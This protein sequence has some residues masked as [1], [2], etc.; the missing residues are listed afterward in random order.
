MSTK[1]FFFAIVMIATMV[2]SNLEGLFAQTNEEFITEISKEKI[3]L[4]KKQSEMIGRLKKNP[5]Y[6]DIKIV[7]LAS[8]PNCQK[9]GIL[10]FTIPGNNEIVE[11]KAT[12]VKALSYGDYEWNGN[13]NDDIGTMSVICTKGKVIA[14]ISTFDNAYEIYSTDNNLYLLIARDVKLEK[15]EKGRCGNQGDKTAILESGIANLA[16][17]PNTV[18]P[19]QD[20]VRILILYTTA[21]SGSVA[22]IQQTAELCISQFNS[23]LY[24]SKVSSNAY[25]ELAGV[26]FFNETAIENASTIQEAVVRLADNATAQQV[27]NSTNADV[28]VL[29]TGSQIWGSNNVGAAR[30]VGPNNNLSY[31][32]VKAQSSIG[33]HYPFVHEVG[34]LYGCYHDIAPDIAGYARGY[35]FRPGF[36]SGKCLTVME[37]GDQLGEGLLNFSNPNVKV[38]GSATGTANNNNA[39][40]IG[41]TFS[42]VSAFRPSPFRPLV[43]SITG[44]QTGNQC[45]QGSWSSIVS[46]GTAPYAYEWSLSYDGFNYNYRSSNE[47]LYEPLTCPVGLYTN[48]YIRLTVTSA[49]GQSTTQF[50]TV[51]VNTPGGPIYKANNNSKIIEDASKEQ[52]Q[53]LDPIPNPTSNEVGVGFILKE[54]AF[55]KLEILDNKGIP[56]KLLANSEFGIGEH[57]L[58]CQL[59]SLPKGLY[60]VTLTTNNFTKSKRIITQ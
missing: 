17:T 43:A 38:S 47:T 26:Q 54:K 16:L 27:R 57:R 56:L 42:T 35:V 46:C 44:T 1:T 19:C 49:D 59:G 15:T 14:Y 24:R 23:A 58:K 9:N 33:Y 60:F 7:R 13:I 34:H 32:V 39:R 41:E 29:L 37:S 45:E 21:A 12:S 51:Y 25:V 5:Y 20:P 2:L 18:V 22:D 28:V 30:T 3:K 40:R 11:A 10:K 8:L 55:V 36:L 48:M 4:T 50:L 6:K 52:I 31:A 53:F